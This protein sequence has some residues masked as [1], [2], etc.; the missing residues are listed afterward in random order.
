[1]DKQN[2]YLGLDMGTSTVGWAVTDTQYRLLRKA[3]KDMWGIREFEEAQTAVERRMNRISRRR[4]QRELARIGLL[5]EYFAEAVEAVDPGFYQRLENSRYWPEDKDSE[6]GTKYSI[7][8][9]SNYTDADYYREYPTI[10]HLRMELIRNPEPHD[11]RLVFLALLNMFKHRG[12]FLFSGQLSAESDGEMR[13]LCTRS[14]ELAEEYLQIP[15]KDISGKQVENILSRSDL[16][17]SNKAEQLMELFGITKK[18]KKETL[19]V[20]GICGLKI[21]A[22]KIFDDLETESKVEFCFSDAS[23]EDKAAELEEQLGETYYQIVLSMKAI[24]DKGILARLLKD[25]TYLSEA[26]IREYEKHKND[27]KALKQVIRKYCSSDEY[28]RMFRVPEDGSYSAY[29]NSTISENEKKCRNM[30]ARKKDEFYVFVKKF[31]KNIEQPGE[32]V[33]KILAD[34][35]ADNFMPKQLTSDNGVIPNQL[36][37]KEMERILENAQTYLPFLNEK[38]ETGLSISERILRLFSFQI[39]YY[40]GPV[41]ENSEKNGGT[42]WVVRKGEGRVLPWNIDRLIDIPATSEQFIKRMVRDCTYMSGEKVLPKSSLLYES[43]CVL[44]EIN[45]IRISGERINVALKQDIYNELFKSGKK[46]TRK[47]LVKYLKNQG[48]LKEDSE[49]SGVD[50]TINNQ[51]NSYGKFYNVFGNVIDTDSGKKMIEDLIY[52]GT[53]FGQDKKLW[54]QKIE[55]QY[56][57][58][59]GTELKR[60][61]GFKFNDWGKFSKAFLEMSGC[62]KSTG[63]IVSLIRCMWETNYN[64]MELLHSEYYSFGEELQNQHKSNFE[65]LSEI[66]PESMEEYYFSAPVRKM[67]W[68][69]LGIIREVEKTL[70]SEP[71]RVFIE[72]TRSEDEKGDKG[73]K[74][75]RKKVLLEKFKGIKDSARDWNA[76]IES[77]DSSGRLR[78]K[79]MFLYISQMGRDMYSGEPIELDELFNDNLYDIDH[80]Y[81]RHFVKDDSIHNNLVL[82]RK[83][84]NAHKSDTYPLESA[85]RNNPSVRDLW[86]FLREKGLITEEKYRR[87]TGRNP[88]TEEQQAE[89]IARQ[90]VETGQATK[91]VADFL[92]EV[93]PETTVVYSKASNVSEFRRNY[94]LLKARSV[95][96]FHHAHDAYLNIVVG[97]AYY[98]KFTQ[99]PLNYVR[100]EYRRGDKNREYNLSRMFDWT[101]R[102]NNETAWEA[103]K[104]DMP[105]TITVV[106]AMLRKNT[107][108]L[109]RQSFT[110]HGAISDATI[111]GKERTKEKVYLPLKSSDKRLTDVTK[112]GGYNK[113]SIAYFTLVEHVVKGKR[114]RTLEAIPVY[115]KERIEKHPEELERYLVEYLELKEVSVRLRKIKIQSLIKVN[116]YFLHVAGKTGAQIILRNAVNLCLGQMWINYIKKLENSQEQNSVGSVISEDKNLELYDILTQKHLKGIYS[117]RPNPVG[118]KLADGRNAFMNASLEKQCAILMQLLNLTKIGGTASDL[119]AIGGAAKSGIMLISKEVTKTEEFLLIQQ[120]VTGLYEKSVDLL[121]V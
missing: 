59:T 116:G 19:W 90:L 18:Q 107:P 104:K 118:Q 113:A 70:G 29:V 111:Y 110:G 79:K 14:L 11:V 50:I 35:D 80:V 86:H 97:N 102:R 112:Y 71:S 42:G 77:E 9:D 106:K 117:K 22:G 69:T 13:I 119:T 89:F 92:K 15:M 52:W 8:N 4:R 108:I 28:D 60:V 31:L 66:T 75:S 87:L 43:Y 46:V 20:R 98:V 88:F 7:F 109:T 49:L 41:T 105:G 61:L 16:S 121:T 5:K 3:G 64:L 21:D 58:I 56:P 82:V 85:I 74:D 57:D 34:I 39:P 17:R 10:F 27:L 25:S 99:N 55:E 23:Y 65:S 45:N 54:R 114:I 48:L 47:Q 120:S 76:L 26:R 94:G 32:D 63:E 72:M 81:P 115:M 73:R 12:H 95:N 36:H 67:M 62:D 53:V 6:V 100:K 68:Q 38:D 91:G 1:M 83:Q 101:I 30:S 2:Y 84:A 96:D 24:Y 33:L 93:L 78:S 103:S 44:N 37:Q 40:I 51:L